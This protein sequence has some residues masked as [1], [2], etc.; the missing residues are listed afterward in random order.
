MPSM[1]QAQLTAWGSPESFILAQADMP[2]ALPGRVVIKNLAAGLNPVDWKTRAGAGIAGMITFDDP[3]VLGWDLAGEVA[4]TGPETS[5]FNVGDLVFGMPAFPDL[6]HCYAEYVQVKVTDIVHAPHGV[7]I[8]TLGAVPL[9][10]LTAYQGLF[11]VGSLKPAQK[12][13]IQGGAGGVGHLAVQ[14][15]SH[16]GAQVWATASPRNQEFLTQ[17]GATPIDYTTTDFTE[18]AGNFDLIFDTVGGEVFTQSLPLLAPQGRIVTCPDPNQI[19]AA[20]AG[21]YDAHWVFVRPNTAHLSTIA[22]ALADKS[23]SVYIERAFPFAQLP[24]AHRLGETGHV[25]GKLVI[26]FDQHS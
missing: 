20:R 22:T 6:G 18:Y 5:G 19:D 14:L 24:E 11:E 10:S 2:E 17:L 16:A 3:V 9:A 23:L 12:V 25:R 15:A 1:T 21:G 26:D 4:A 8:L 7:D 13:L